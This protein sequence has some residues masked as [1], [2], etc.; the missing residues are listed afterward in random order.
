MKIS[1]SELRLVIRNFLIKESMYGSSLLLENANEDLLYEAIINEINIRHQLLPILL[2]IAPVF[3]CSKEDVKQNKATPQTVAAAKVVVK[4]SGFSE[5]SAHDQQ[6]VLDTCENGMRVYNS[7]SATMKI[8]GKDVPV[9]EALEWE[10]CHNP[11]GAKQVAAAI[12][13]TDKLK[14]NA[15]DQLQKDIVVHD[16]Q[17]AKGTND[18][19]K[20][21]W[22]D[23]DDN[24]DIAA[25]VNDN[26]ELCHVFPGEAGE[27]DRIMYTATC[28][29]PEGVKGTDIGEIY[30]SK[31]PLSDEQS[32]QLDLR[33]KDNALEAMERMIKSIRPKKMIINGQKISEDMLILKSRLEAGTNAMLKGLAEEFYPDMLKLH[34]EWNNAE[35]NNL[36]SEKPKIDKK[37]QN[38][39]DRVEIVYLKNLKQYQK[40]D[41]AKRAE[42]DKLLNF[43]F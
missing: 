37:I 26:P 11:E 4:D 7:V 19:R 30:D 16:T 21:F 12:L 20:S 41:K 14:D 33:D 29:H 35:H 2:M 28:W 8:D 1:E 9:G 34:K 23:S 27:P 42:N 32:N 10:T 31:K 22:R 39:L 38:L 15:E 24:K 3:G 25:A 13:D 43:N 36:E 5:L 6:F 18:K 40:D 17:D